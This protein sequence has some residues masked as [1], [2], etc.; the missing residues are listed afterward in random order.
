MTTSK[1]SEL[2]V[3]RDD[4]LVVLAAAFANASAGEG[5]VITI[6]GDPGIGKTALAREAMTRVDNQLF[7]TGV[8]RCREQ[9]DAPPFWPWNQALNMARRRLTAPGKDELTGLI[10][11]VV[12]T[13]AEGT[14]GLDSSQFQFFQ[15]VVESLRSVCETRPLVVMLDDL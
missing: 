5:S 2:F 10:D 3:G 1:H 8:G 4:E 12:G 6:A 11:R 9:R 14:S 13:L 15:R 7:A